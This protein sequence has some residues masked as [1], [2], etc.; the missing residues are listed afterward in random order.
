MSFVNSFLFNHGIFL[1]LTISTVDSVAYKISLTKVY[2]IAVCPLALFMLHGIS[3]FFFCIG[4][5]SFISFCFGFQFLSLFEVVDVNFHCSGV[6]GTGFQAAGNP[7]EE[8]D[9][10]PEHEDKTDC[11]GN[12]NCLDSHHSIIC[13]RWLQLLMILFFF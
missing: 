5:F 12:H 7:D 1:A 9:V 11:S 10:V 3:T 8:K 2:G 6:T 13:L 4:L